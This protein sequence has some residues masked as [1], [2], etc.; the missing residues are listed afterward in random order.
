MTARSF[1][2]VMAHVELLS[3][4]FA[5]RAPRHDR[6]GSFAFE[7]VEDL[8]SAGL[9]RLP[10]P[11]ALGGDGFTLFQCVQVLRRIARA[12]ASTA[13]GL[14]MHFHVV[15]TLAETHAWPEAAFER[16][17]REIVSDG[18]LVNSAASEP[19]MG[20]P[21]RGG[22]PATTAV[23]VPGGFVI[24]GYKRWVTYAPAL[25]YFLVT[26]QLDGGIG[27]FV[28]ANDAPGLT[29]IDNWSHSLSLRAS[30]SFDVQLK[31]VFVRSEWHVEQREAGQA[32]RGGLP[33]GWPTCAFAAVYLG[34]G[35]GALLALADYAWQR[36]PTA[37]GKP[38]A[39]L[40]SLQR[41][42]GQMDVALRAAR[43]VLEETA[44]RW[45]EH[46][47]ARAEMEAD[48]AA[49]KHLCTN[50]AITVTD[51]ALRAAGASGL[52]AT[53]PLERY[54]RDARAGLMHPPQDDRALEVI[55]KSV[56]AGRLSRSPETTESM[57]PTGLEPVFRP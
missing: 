49:A 4:R 55:G 52:E 13:L 46:P 15:G 38:I 23:R 50:A 51:I 36:T 6:E 10:V 56:L 14:A 44:R 26:A 30:G 40:P 57:P 20:S 27:V 9:P 42:I 37:L 22:L 1:A 2:D 24:N 34:V 17:C 33:T 41:S 45:S 47:E 8:R 48:L 32:K 18:A 11:V 25:R 19:A 21:S 39:E 35:E 3:T 29:L 31:D 28:V 43:A 53:L 54:F 12:D 7:N 5:E 16:L